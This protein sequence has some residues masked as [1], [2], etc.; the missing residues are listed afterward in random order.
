M[1]KTN[2]QNITC[3]IGD[4]K[5][6]DFIKWQKTTGEI[7]SRQQQLLGESCINGNMATELGDHDRM[8]TKGI[9]GSTSSCAQHSTG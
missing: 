4:N 2:W 7:T 5:I 1:N 3:E 9:I 6:G 8:A